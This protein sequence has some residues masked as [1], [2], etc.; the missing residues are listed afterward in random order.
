MRIAP[1]CRSFPV[2]SRY[3]PV[4]LLIVALLVVTAPLARA[5]EQCPA[6]QFGVKGIAIDR[7]GTTAEEAQI[8]GIQQAAR[9]GFQR[10]LLR[11]LRDG[12]VTA[13]F[14]EGHAPDQFVDFYHIAE[15]NSLEGRYIAELDYCFQAQRL[16]A[17]MRAAGLQLSL[18]HI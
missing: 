18:I 7:A 15:E 3:L 1:F 17:A 16:R 2:L 6:P 5:F 9:I 14:I 12:A 10:V 4:G 13:T 11:L 8:L